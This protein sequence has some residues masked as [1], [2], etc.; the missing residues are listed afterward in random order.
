[1]SQKQDTNT[2]YCSVAF[3]AYNLGD[4]NCETQKTS[5]FRGL[6]NDSPNNYVRL[7]KVG[8]GQ[9]AALVKYPQYL[10]SKSFQRT[11]NEIGHQSFVAVS[12]QT[13]WRRYLP[14]DGISINAVSL[15]LMLMTCAW[16]SQK[17][18]Q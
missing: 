7:S 1:M 13:P 17:L 16:A 10:G 11:V 9:T 2:E 15:L 14:H 12:L 3:D 18:F 5:G 8:L 6:S 4:G